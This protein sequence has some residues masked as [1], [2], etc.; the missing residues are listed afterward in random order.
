M[1]NM[2]RRQGESSGKRDIAE[3]ALERAPRE[4]GYG[5]GAASALAFMKRLERERAKA[6]PQDERPAS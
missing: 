6:R 5:E 3:L 1:G 4:R 2:E